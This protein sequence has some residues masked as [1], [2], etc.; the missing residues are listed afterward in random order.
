MRRYRELGAEKATIDGEMTEIKNQID[1]DVE[2]GFKMNIDG[3]AVSKR[4][5]NR[6]F[7][8]LL[9]V[10]LLDS[11]TKQSCVVT[12]YDAKKLRAAIEEQGL[13]E[14]AMVPSLGNAVLK[15]A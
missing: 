12:S 3:L 15:L 2:V 10:S 4:S 8:T 14:Q 1:A 9:A 7:D 5:P 11:D 13:L 6:S